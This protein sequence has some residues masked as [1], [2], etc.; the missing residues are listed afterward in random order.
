MP[1]VGAI[2]RSVECPLEIGIRVNFLDKSM[3]QICN[4]I[5]GFYFLV[6]S[7]IKKICQN[8]N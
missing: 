3:S 5:Y 8:K 6:K 2:R 1:L 4:I 7:E